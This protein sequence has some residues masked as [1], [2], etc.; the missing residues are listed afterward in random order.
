MAWLYEAC[1]TCQSP[2]GW[3]P[4]MRYLYHAASSGQC[5]LQPKRRE[6]P[7]SYV[8][9]MASDNMGSR[10]HDLHTGGFYSSLRGL[11]DTPVWWEYRAV[12][13]PSRCRFSLIINLS[14]TSE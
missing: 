8:V 4:R 14:K 7:G 5:L 6:K 12:E 10:L 3:F 2:F 9:P 13:D 1:A 11:S